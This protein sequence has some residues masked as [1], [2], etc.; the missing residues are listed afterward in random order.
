MLVVAPQSLAVL[1]APLAAD[2]GESWLL[3]AALVCAVIALALYPYAI[4]KF[5]LREL[6]AG[7]G[8]HWIAGGAL[9]ISALSFSELA[10]AAEGLQGPHR[11]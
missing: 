2:W 8:E 10:L 7:Q 6:L 1:A 3:D 4:K 5:S 11:R 9:A